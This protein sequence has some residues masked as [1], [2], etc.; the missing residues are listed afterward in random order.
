MLL[1]F[2]WRIYRLDNRAGNLPSVAIFAYITKTGIPEG[3]PA[4]CQNKA[5]KQKKRHPLK[6]KWHCETSVKLFLAKT[7]TDTDICIITEF[8]TIVNPSENERR[9]VYCCLFSGLCRF[10]CNKHINTTPTI[11]PIIIPA[12]NQIIFISILP[13]TENIKNAT[14]KAA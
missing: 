11:L 5:G 13:P 4:L 12:K 10:I 8:I 6:S 7:K 14:I 9:R 1:S 3:L 2:F